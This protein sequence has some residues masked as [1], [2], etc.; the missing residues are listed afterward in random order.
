MG[1]SIGNP[2]ASLFPIALLLELRLYGLAK[3]EPTLP[4]NRGKGWSG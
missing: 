1:P 4:V 2:I 3:R